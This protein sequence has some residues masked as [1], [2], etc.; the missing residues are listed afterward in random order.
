M[1]F[2]LSELEEAQA[3]FDQSKTEIDRLL[4]DVQ[5]AK[6]SQLSGM[7]DQTGSEFAVLWEARMNIANEAFVEK[8]Q[9]I[10][11]EFAE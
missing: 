9:K 1:E 8:E 6:E 4:K 5:D 7:Y 11:Q 3:F 10:D 2:L